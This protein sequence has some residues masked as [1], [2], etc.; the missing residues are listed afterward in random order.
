MQTINHTYAICAYK[1]S[2][3]LEEC[4]ISLKN[5]SIPSEIFLAT[6][7][8]NER[9]F[10]L[11]EYYSLPLYINKN[12]GGIVQDWNYALDHV[13]TKYATIAHQDDIYESE[14]TKMILERMERSLKPLIAF[15]DYY[16]LRNE[17]KIYNTLMLRIKKLMLLPMRIETFSHSKI[18]RRRM[19]S[20]GDPICC[21]SVTYC[22]KYLEMP[23]F[24]SG[25][26][27]C[28]DW[29]AWEHISKLEGDF[30]YI[31]YPLMGHRIH[32]E[33]ETTAII[34]DR[35]RVEENYKMYCKFW[36][37]WIAKCINYI[38]TL[39]EHFNQLN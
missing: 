6:S 27:S 2:K 22:M 13:K 12:G 17:E 28:E 38:Y 1:E 21:P 25:F 39:S 23:I 3:Y 37:K 26:R 15:T 29:Q 20:I 34:K 31:P 9:I 19:L 18:I 5:Q 35:K 8:P 10:H 24:Q 4:I 32:Q 11:A 16:E 7:T 14:Y 33:S 36:P 30:L